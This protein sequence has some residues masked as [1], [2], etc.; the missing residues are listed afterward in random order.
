MSEEK[1]SSWEEKYNNNKLEKYGKV[2]G[3]TFYA[4]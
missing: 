3:K 4:K 1:V 2:K